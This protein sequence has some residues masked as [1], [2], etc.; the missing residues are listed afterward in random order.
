MDSLGEK[1][2]LESI[3]ADGGQNKTPDMIRAERAEGFLNVE[4]RSL[5]VS[6]FMRIIHALLEYAP[7]TELKM[8]TIRIIR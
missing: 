7:L 2:I 4:L 3:E 8:N 5:N 6:A 1:N